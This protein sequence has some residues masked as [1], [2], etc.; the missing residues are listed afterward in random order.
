M[1]I[2]AF[3]LALAAC[4][5]DPG[6]NPPADPPV[7]LVGRADLSVDRIDL[8]DAAFDVPLVGSVTL[9]NVGDHPLTLRSAVIRDGAGV[10][11]T[12]EATNLNRRLEDGDSYDILVV[13]R[14]RELPMLP[15]Q[16][17]LIVQTNDPQSALVELAVTCTPAPA[18]DDDDTDG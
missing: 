6:I 9:S 17:A 3:G 8:V 10:I 14:Y 12:D 1:R 4:S 11:V 2:A 13:C 15:V 5:P 16:A 7:V 18:D